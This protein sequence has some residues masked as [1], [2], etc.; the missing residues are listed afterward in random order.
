MRQ[1]DPCSPVHPLTVSIV[2]CGASSWT[3]AE[4]PFRAATGPSSRRPGS[5]RWGLSGRLGVAGLA[6]QVVTAGVKNGRRPASSTGGQGPGGRSV[7]WFPSHRQAASRTGALGRPAR[8]RRC[9]A[10][11]PPRSAPAVTPVQ[12]GEDRAPDRDRAPGRA[13]AVGQRGS[14]HLAAR[15]E[16]RRIV[17]RRPGYPVAA[18]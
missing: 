18:R 15:G 14:R 17:R 13:P 8:R 10:R 4:P 5:Y 16:V 12:A 3:R 6:H 11:S 9:P 2:R 1:A 7:R